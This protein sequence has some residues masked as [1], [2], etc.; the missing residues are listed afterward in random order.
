MLRK[1]NVKNKGSNRVNDYEPIN[2][3]TKPL[4]VNNTCPKCGK[5]NSN[6]AKFCSGCGG[7]LV[8]HPGIYCP[9]CGGMNFVNAKFC[10]EC[11]KE[12]DNI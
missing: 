1:N 5:N 12:F 8:D 10:Q 7:N 9:E 6:V 4:N 2:K 3:L 11:G